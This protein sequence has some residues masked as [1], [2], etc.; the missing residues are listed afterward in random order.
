MKDETTVIMRRP[1]QTVLCEVCG[2]NQR[3]AHLRL[4]AKCNAD[5]VGRAFVDEGLI[6]PSA[7][8]SQHLKEAAAVVAGWPEWKRNALGPMAPSTASQ[9]ASVVVTDTLVEAVEGAVGM[10]HGAWDMVDPKELIAASYRAVRA[11]MRSP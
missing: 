2:T 10:G 5:P 11:A 4:C 3:Q 9:A 1:S 7:A 6:S 8:F